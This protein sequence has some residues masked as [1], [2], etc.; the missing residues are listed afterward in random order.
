MAAVTDA[1]VRFAP[2]V[3]A[4]AVRYVES[5][6]LDH[7]TVA[8]HFIA[9]GI[10]LKA[11][12]AFFSTL[13]ALVYSH[14]LIRAGKVAAGIGAFNPV[15]REAYRKAGGHAALR[16]CMDDD[17]KLGAALRT[18]GARQDLLA[19]RPGVALLQVG[20]LVLLFV[21]PALWAVAGMLGALAGVQVSGRVGALARPSSCWPWALRSPRV[22]R[23]P[24]RQNTG[25]TRW[26]C[27]RQYG[28]RG[29]A[30]GWPGRLPGPPG[31]QAAVSL[32]FDDALDCQP[33]VAVP[34][35]EAYGVRGTF[36]VNPGPGSRRH[37]A[38]RGRVR[39]GG[40]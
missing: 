14:R 4:R 35:L 24:R 38:G 28:F 11:L 10:W 36:Y 34:L 19:Y 20:G 22:G 25:L 32:S 2:D 16:L 13:V 8:P 40:G 23:A 26:D 27:I 7:L 3:V 30:M 17:V 31:V 29:R 18:E 39:V 15:R 33:A 1:D 12:L 37:G 21:V 6:G 5:E 9:R